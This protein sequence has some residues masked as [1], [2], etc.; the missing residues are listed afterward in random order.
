[1]DW[2][3]KLPLCGFKPACKPLTSV[4]KTPLPTSANNSSCDFL[5]GF[6]YKNEDETP[7]LPPP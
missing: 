6:K 1:M 3:E 7:F 2:S 4:I 5:P